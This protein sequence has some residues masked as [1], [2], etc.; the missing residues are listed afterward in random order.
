MDTDK[1]LADRVVAH[2]NVDLAVIYPYNLLAAGTPLMHH[3]MHVTKKSMQYESKVI[4]FIH[5]L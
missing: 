3:I 5:F 1:V 4:H 2:L